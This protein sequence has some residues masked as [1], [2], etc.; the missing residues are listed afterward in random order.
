MLYVTMYFNCTCLAVFFSLQRLWIY[1]P[2]SSC[3]WNHRG[4]RTSGDILSEQ[5]SLPRI[6]QVLK[7]EFQ[8]ITVHVCESLGSTPFPDMLGHTTALVSRV[9]L[10]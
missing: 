10:M 5:A 3:Q 4:S 2:G 1:N 9:V 7:L 6:G 8:H